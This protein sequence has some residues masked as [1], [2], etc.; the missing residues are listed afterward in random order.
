MAHDEVL[1]APSR[2]GTGAQTH[3]HLLHPFPSPTGVSHNVD[4][5]KPVLWG[6]QAWVQAQTLRLCFIS[7]SERSTAKSNSWDTA[8]TH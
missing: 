8:V 7:A 5:P 3:H 1:A 6:H 4:R 2:H